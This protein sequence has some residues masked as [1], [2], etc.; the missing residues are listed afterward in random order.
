[1]PYCI[2][3]TV[4]TFSTRLWPWRGRFFAIHIKWRNISISEKLWFLLSYSA[5][6][7]CGM[8]YTCAAFVKSILS[9]FEVIYDYWFVNFGRFLCICILPWN[10]VNAR[11]VW[12]ILWCILDAKLWIWTKKV[13]SQIFRFERWSADFEGQVYI[14]VWFV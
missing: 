7:Q 14:C 3:W 5:R 6:L 11:L 2:I 1:M 4:D 10:S 9:S 12:I 13:L 8:L